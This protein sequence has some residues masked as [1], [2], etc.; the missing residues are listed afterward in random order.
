MIFSLDL[1]IGELFH[2]YPVLLTV[3]VVYILQRRF[4]LRMY[5]TV[6]LVGWKSHLFFGLFYEFCSIYHCYRLVV[7]SYTQFISSHNTVNIALNNRRNLGFP[8]CGITS[9]FLLVTAKSND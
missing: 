1:F 6:N 7:L 2:N 8:S 5:P 4:V 9:Q 3:Q